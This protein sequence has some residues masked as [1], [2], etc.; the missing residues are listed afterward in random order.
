MSRDEKYSPEEYE[1]LKSNQGQSLHVCQPDISAHKN[2]GKSLDF[3]SAH[4]DIESPR[5]PCTNWSGKGPRGGV[6]LRWRGFVA[7]LFG[8]GL[9]F[10]M[11]TEAAAQPSCA[12]TDV[13]ITGV[14]PA[15]SDPAALAGDCA[16]LLGFM[17]TLR[18]TAS[19]HWANSLSMATWD[20]ITVTG[21]RVSALDLRSN[22]LTGTI[23]AALN[24]LTGLQELLLHT[25]QLTGS[26][27]TLSSLTSLQDLQL[28][29]NDLSG[30]IPDLSGLTSLQI[31][32]LDS[33]RLSGSIPRT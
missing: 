19:L 16:T 15:P 2:T 18:G 9:A 33:N 11:A 13:A 7:A 24:S 6:G 23:P 32:Y 12:T 29:E 1:R 31:L 27:P 4:F 10:G 28:Q 14:T 8:L 5:P 17:D 26:I 30:E 21:S 22:Q 20:G 3:L 25:N